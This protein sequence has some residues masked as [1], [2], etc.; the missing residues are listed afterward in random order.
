MTLQLS[1]QAPE[2]ARQFKISVDRALQRLENPKNPVKFPIFAD[3]SVMPPASNWKGC[4]LY[5]D[6]ISMMCISDGTNWLRVDT[7]ASV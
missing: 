3:S 4:Q 2:W 5:K 6:D 7:G 1:P